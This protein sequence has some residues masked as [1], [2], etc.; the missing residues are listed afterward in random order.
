[1]AARTVSG[2]SCSVPRIVTCRP[3][4]S[5]TTMTTPCR[6]P[7]RATGQHMRNRRRRG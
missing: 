2:L 5:D 4:N 3:N 7:R 1:L 6:S